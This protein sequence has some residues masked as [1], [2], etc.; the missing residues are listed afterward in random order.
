MQYYL[1]LKDLQS[2][3]N[4]LFKAIHSFCQQRG[5]IILLRGALGAGKTA[6]VQS[7]VHMYGAAHVTSPTFN[8]IQSY[9]ILYG[10]RHVLYHYDLYKY[11]LQTAL[12]LGILEEFEKDGLHFVEWGEKDLEKI[13][14]K[15]GI[16]P[17]LNIEIK[18]VEGSNKRGYWIQ[19][20]TP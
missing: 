10:N 12:E 3:S 18:I 8:F 17:L 2:Q 20:C 9:D 13:C 15:V 16:M 7:F 14:F 11:D 4:P 19:T 5:K 6:F 1:D